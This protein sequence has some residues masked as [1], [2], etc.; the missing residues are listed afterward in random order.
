M[1]LA[2][3]NIIKIIL[4]L[5]LLVAIGFAMYLFKDNILSFFENLPG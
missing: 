5:I 3:D 2:I 1:N 4:G